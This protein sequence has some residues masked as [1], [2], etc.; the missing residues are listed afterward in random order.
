[1]KEDNILIDFHPNDYIIRLSPFVDEKGNWTGELMV[2]TISTADNVMNDTDHY[3]L[4]HLTQMVCAAIPAMEASEVVRDL[5]TEIVEE[6]KDQ[7]DITEE[8]ETKKKPNITSVDENIINV[9]FN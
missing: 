6:A 5:L 2:G 3:Q 8:T 1:M 9:K 4:M 7:D